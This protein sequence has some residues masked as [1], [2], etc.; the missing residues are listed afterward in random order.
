MKKNI[1]FAPQIMTCEVVAERGYQASAEG[2]GFN[3]PGYG[4][5]SD[6]LI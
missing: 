3:L 4:T 2:P 5:E 6:E 1:Y